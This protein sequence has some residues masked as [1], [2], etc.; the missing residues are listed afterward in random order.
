MGRVGPATC[1]TGFPLKKIASTG[2]S[3]GV[4]RVET[5]LAAERVAFAGPIA[6]PIAR[7]KAL[8]PLQAAGPVREWAHLGTS[9]GR[10]YV[11][12]RS[13][14]WQPWVKVPNDG[15]WHGLQPMLAASQLQ[16]TM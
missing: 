4:H 8:Q 14:A 13:P 5:R 15:S 7:P 11:T 2:V 12:N 9:H 1:S 6:G 16:C 10:S 3:S